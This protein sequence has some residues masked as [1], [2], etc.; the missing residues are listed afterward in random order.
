MVLAKMPKVTKNNYLRELEKKEISNSS[1]I[2]KILFPSSHWAKN[3]FTK[4]EIL[5]LKFLNEP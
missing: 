4:H 3:Y 2:L 1:P 5:Y